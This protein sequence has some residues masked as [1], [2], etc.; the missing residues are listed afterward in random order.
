MKCDF[1]DNPVCTRCACG[2]LACEEHSA[3]VQ[4][5]HWCVACYESAKSDYESE[6]YEHS[7]DRHR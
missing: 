1:C 7:L 3:L 5:V 4:D 2:H 6:K